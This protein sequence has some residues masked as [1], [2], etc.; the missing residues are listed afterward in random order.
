MTGNIRMGIFAHRIRQQL[1][2][3]QSFMVEVNWRKSGHFLEKLDK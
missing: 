1:G 2:D 3:M